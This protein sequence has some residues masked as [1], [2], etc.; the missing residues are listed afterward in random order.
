MTTTLI[1]NFGRK[2]NYLRL[3]LTDKCNLRC[4]Y[5]M[6]ENIAFSP[7]HQL[8]SSEEI[9][10]ITTKFVALGITKI[11]LTGGEPLARKD[12]GTILNNLSKLPV[13]LHLSTNAVLLHKY[14]TELLHSPIEELNISLDSLKPAKFEEITRRNDYQQVIENI[15]WA[16]QAN[17]KVKINIVLMRGVNDDE[18]LDFVS[19]AKE[20]NVAVRFIEFMPFGGNSWSIDKRVPHDEVTAVIENKFGNELTEITTQNHATSSEFTFKEGKGSIGLISTISKPFC[21]DCNRVRLT[22]DGK[23]KNCLFSKNEVNLLKAIRNQQDIT[24]LIIGDIKNKKEERG[25]DK[26][27]NDFFIQADKEN[28]R[29]MVKIGG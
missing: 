22:A 14:K 17:F 8:M 26:N 4:F 21:G 20:N 28:N 11:R 6:P 16:I 27:T 1:D 29:S 12:F 23:M 18:I 13:S 3:S 25:G 19:F 7:S 10:V 24:P 15:H 9:E 5:C 2:H